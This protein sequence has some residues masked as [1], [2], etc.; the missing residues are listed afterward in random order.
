[1]TYR[2]DIEK[3]WAQKLH[4]PGGLEGLDVLW[5]RGKLGHG[6]DELGPRFLVL[7]ENLKENIQNE[8]LILTHFSQN[9][10]KKLTPY[11]VS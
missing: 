7:L 3:K 1:M 5:T 9:L 6:L 2:D 10:G 4:D 11:V 8:R